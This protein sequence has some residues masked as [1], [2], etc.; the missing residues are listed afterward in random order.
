VVTDNR[1]AR[2]ILRDG[3]LGANVAY[4]A[5]LLIAAYNTYVQGHR[6]PRGPNADWAAFDA[7]FMTLLAITIAAYA[8]CHEMVTV[9]F[10]KNG[11]SRGVL[12]MT[13][14]LAGF[15]LLAWVVAQRSDAP[16]WQVFALALL[17]A[18]LSGLAARRPV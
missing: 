16:G 6:T 5:G 4:V 10:W 9:S 1:E 18:G 17:A 14:P 3:A 7:A 15:L 8:A 11:F 2:S 13:L 12:W